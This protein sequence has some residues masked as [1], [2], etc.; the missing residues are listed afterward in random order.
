[1]INKTDRFYQF[2][3]HHEIIDHS[4]CHFWV[5]GRLS[6]LFTVHSDDLLV[7]SQ[8]SHKIYLFC[9][10]RIFS[11]SSK[12]RR[13]MSGGLLYCGYIPH[14]CTRCPLYRWGTFKGTIAVIPHHG[15]A[16]KYLRY[17]MIKRRFFISRRA[18]ARE[19]DYEM[20]SVRACVCACVS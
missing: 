7:S 8:I 9:H 20:M 4:F 13:E 16:S 17:F 10:C 14:L 3:L 6:T 15:Q 12:S 5:S 18:L 2:E 11:G 1:M 19:G